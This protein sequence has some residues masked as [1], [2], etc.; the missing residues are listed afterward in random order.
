MALIAVRSWASARRRCCG[1][2]A[3]LWFESFG[4]TARSRVNLGESGRGWQVFKGAAS[5]GHRQ[6]EF[7]NFLGFL[8][9]RYPRREIHPI[10]D[11]CGT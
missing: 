1:P 6:V 8:D 2:C 3:W 5:P 9:R 11:N 7:I 10:C 4:I